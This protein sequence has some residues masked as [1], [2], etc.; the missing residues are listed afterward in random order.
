MIIQSH[1]DKVHHFASLQ[2]HLFSKINIPE[3]GILAIDS[4]LPVNECAE[5]YTR[6][7]KEVRINHKRENNKKSFLH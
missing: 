2:G 6:K 1:L 3:S 4:S 5:D 7:L